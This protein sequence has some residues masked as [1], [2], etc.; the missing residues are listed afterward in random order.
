[1]TQGV[2]AGR[3]PEPVDAY[4]EPAE[5]VATRRPRASSSR[6]RSRS[7]SRTEVALACAAAAFAGAAMAIAATGA[8]S[9]A[10]TGTLAQEI[11]LLDRSREDVAASLARLSA[12]V[13]ALRRSADA[14]AARLAKLEA[15]SAGASAEIAL[16]LD[17]MSALVSPSGVSTP[18]T[19]AASS[20]LA[21]LLSRIGRIETALT[22]AADAPRTTRQVQLALREVDDRITR[23]SE[24]DERL[25][26]SLENRRLALMA[27][28]TALAET[29]AE[30]ANL[31]GDTA[32]ARPAAEPGAVQHASLAMA[33]DALAR[34]AAGDRPFLAHQQRLALLAPEDADIA[35]LMTPARRGVASRETLRRSFAG[36]ERLARGDVDDG[37]RWLRSTVWRPGDGA[38][39][40]RAAATLT[41]ARRAV[42]DGDMTAAAVA[43]SDLQPIAARPFRAWR[44]E[45][46]LRGDLDHRL[47]V[48]RSRLLSPDATIAPG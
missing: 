32:T 26:A 37:W 9:G 36:A 35:A 31:G 13:Q 25:S 2:A 4:F 18:P 42:D 16:V 19:D 41:A 24:S 6:M 15:Q 45:A 1:M 21:A 48:L 29:R 34:A 11:D 10:S 27:V 20:P 28:A 3:E 22:D 12:D 7:A 38:V 23:L 44:Q 33:F 14:D 17:Q 8:R 40:A 47:D 46:V 5:P 30:I 39:D 43:L